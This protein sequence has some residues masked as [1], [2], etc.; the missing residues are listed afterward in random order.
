MNP[1]LTIVRSKSRSTDDNNQ[2]QD[3]AEDPDQYLP[4]VMTCV[5]YLKVPDYSSAQVLED[6]F[7]K[8]LH[9][10]QHSFLLS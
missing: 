5:N 1:R 9:L 6:R 7:E 3:K 4:S 2:Q 8:A 10:G